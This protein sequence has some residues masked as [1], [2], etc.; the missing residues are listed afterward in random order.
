MFK[1]GPVLVTGAGGFIGAHLCRHLKGIENLSVTGLSRSPGRGYHRLDI[2]DRT[3]LKRF[4][5]HRR[6]QVIFHLAGGRDGG[7][8]GIINDNLSTTVSLFETIHCMKDYH[9]RVVVLSSA[10]EYGA[11]AGPWRPISEKS[12]AN[13]INLYGRIKALQTQAALE[14]ARWGEDVVIAR[15]FNITGPGVPDTISVGYFARSIVALERKQGAQLSFKV[16]HLGGIRDFLD[17]GDICEALYRLS[18]KGKKGEIYN[19][20][21]QKKVIMRDLLRQMIALSR[22]PRIKF[23]EDRLAGCGPLYSVGACAKFTRLTGWR[24]RTGLDQ[25]LINTLESYR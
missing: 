12:A 5:S 23:S 21:S 22:N 2:L 14:Y 7:P 13:P 19:I 25:S 10:A 18:I 20:C 15:L 3:A 17:I 4:L 8:M 6:P 16:G 24:P 1:F 9:P 11:A